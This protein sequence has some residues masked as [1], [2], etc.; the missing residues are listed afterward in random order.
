LSN[1]PFL[2]K[3]KAFQGIAAFNPLLAISSALTLLSVFDL[4]ISGVYIVLVIFVPVPYQA[5]SVLFAPV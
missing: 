2:E 5:I 3:S 1:A 4:Y